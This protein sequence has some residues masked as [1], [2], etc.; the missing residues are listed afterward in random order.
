MCIKSTLGR[1]KPRRDVRLVMM[2]GTLRRVIDWARFLSRESAPRTAAFDVWSVPES[3][4]RKNTSLWVIKSKANGLEEIP[5]DTT[6]QAGRASCCGARR[7]HELCE[8]VART[9]TLAQRW[10][11][12][13][14]AIRRQQLTTVSHPV[15]PAP[16][17]QFKQII[18]H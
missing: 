11:S 2:H 5:S 1:S 3:N 9:E 10:F 14:I 16:T 8:F 17:A 6:S 4:N 18:M 7:F 15:T 12:D 13:W